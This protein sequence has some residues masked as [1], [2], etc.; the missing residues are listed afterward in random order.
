M[1]VAWVKKKAR[2]GLGQVRD[3][4]AR[5]VGLGREGMAWLVV[6]AG[7][8]WDG[9]GLSYWL[10]SGQS[11]AARRV[12]GGWAGVDCRFGRGRGVTD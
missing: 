4:T 9:D 6:S 5:R 11:D 2:E 10:G 8:G 3:G 7:S 1:R 12:G